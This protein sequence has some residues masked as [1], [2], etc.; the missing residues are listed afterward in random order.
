MHPYQ[1]QQSPPF[2]FVGGQPPAPAPRRRNP[3]AIALIVL[4]AVLSVA[5]VL[6]AA[7]LGIRYLTFPDGP[8]RTPPRVCATLTGA[9]TRELIGAGTPLDGK[10]LGGLGDPENTCAIEFADRGTLDIAVTYRYRDWR[11][12]GIDKAREGFANRS[13]LIRQARVL[14]A[15][16]VIAGAGDE[17]LCVGVADLD[18]VNV[19]YDCVIRDGNA[20]IDLTYQP[21]FAAE[22]DIP[23][24]NRVTARTLPGILDRTVTEVIRPFALDVVAGLT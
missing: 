21:S 22:S 8:H 9:Q 10:G 19:L 7:F 3:A 18:T 14:S 2:V 23:E 12:S 16:T 24:E 20:R 1:P 5:V 15:E 4:S 11:S 6:P 17:S 13:S